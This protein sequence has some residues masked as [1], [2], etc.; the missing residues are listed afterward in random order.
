VEFLNLLRRESGASFAM[1]LAMAVTLALA[2]VLILWTINHVVWAHDVYA[3]P[4]KFIA[5]FVILVAIRQ[6][7]QLHVLR[8]GGDEIMRII[9]KVRTRVIEKYRRVDMKSTELTDQS[10][11]LINTIGNVSTIGYLSLFVAILFKDVLQLLFVM[12]YIYYLS[13]TQFLLVAAMMVVIAMKF[14]ESALKIDARMQDMQASDKRFMDVAGDLMNGFKEI[15]MNRQRSDALNLEIGQVSLQNYGANSALR[16]NVLRNYSS[17]EIILFAFL[18]LLIFIEP[19]VT[20]TANSVVIQVAVAV[21][22]MIGTV[23][24]AVGTSTEFMILGRISTAL[25]DM[26]GQIDRLHRDEGERPPS[27]WGEP[28]RSLSAHELIYDN[29]D[30]LS[31]SRFTIGPANLELKAGEIAFLTGSNGSGKSTLLRVLCGLY[32]A[33]AGEYRINGQAL[34]QDELARLRSLFS[35][36][37]A[38]YYLFPKLHGVPADAALRAER[39]I[40]ELGLAGKTELKDGAFTTLHL[41]SGQR[42]RIALIAALLED[43]PIYVFDEWAA[44]QDPVFRER[45]YKKILPDLR[46]AGKLVIA[47]THDQAYFDCCDRLFEVRSGVPREIPVAVPA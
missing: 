14:W 43:R 37:F 39:L 25:T 11:F 24:E 13:P 29:I 28:F 17:S 22:F 5:I 10:T 27:P 18:G 20:H 38:D 19:R 30:V 16:G 7:S 12:V 42:T 33:Q 41:S 47:V 15:K 23:R 35:V 4:E 46:D 8:V 44:D 32:G 31:K 1:Y 26:E 36:V 34:T 2:D 45:F 9:H 21:T 6:F 3:I 40:E